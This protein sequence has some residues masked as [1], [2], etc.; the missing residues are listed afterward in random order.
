M[1]SSP[2]RREKG[3]NSTRVLQFLCALLVAF[4]GVFICA[5]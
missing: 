2:Y 1:P 3:V 4:A 5:S